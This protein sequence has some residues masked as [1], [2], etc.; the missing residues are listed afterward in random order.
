MVAATKMR[1]AQQAAHRAAPL[2]QP[3][4]R[5][6]RAHL[7]QPRAE[8]GQPSAA[9]E[10]H[11]KSG[12]TAVV[13]LTSEKGL[14]GPLNTNLLR[15]VLQADDPNKVYI[16][17][18]RK[19]RQV[20][21]RLKK[22][23]LADFELKD[24][25]TF[26]ESKTISRFL[27]AEIRRG[28]VRRGRDFLQPLRQHALA[29]PDPLPARADRRRRARGRQGPGRGAAGRAHGPV[30]RRQGEGPPSPTISS[31]TP[32]SCSA[33]CCPTTC[34]CSSTT[35]SSSRAPPSTA[36]AWSP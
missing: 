8:R 4:R 26:A 11:G 21:A 20:L 7:R 25:P 36:R 13:V 16:S 27:L 15:D 19:G 10:A 24:S 9:P 5:H 31:P 17:V 30:A 33:S 22:N 28:R 23:L 32:T 29:G 34:T 2:R 14:C 6:G 1:R 35:R 3:P 18:G 12:K